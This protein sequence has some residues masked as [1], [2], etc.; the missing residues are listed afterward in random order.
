MFEA[1][2]ER[3]KGPHEES[4]DWSIDLE[5]IGIECRELSNERGSS[6]E[7]EW[8][9]V[10]AEAGAG[11]PCGGSLERGKKRELGGGWWWMD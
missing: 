1:R 5:Q 2:Q 7:L 6:T 11:W 8:Y 9:C 4:I 3:D 10:E